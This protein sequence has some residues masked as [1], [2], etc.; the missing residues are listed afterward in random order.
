LRAAAYYR[1]LATTLPPAELGDAALRRVRRAAIRSVHRL[2][3]WRSRVDIQA[4]LGV[5]SVDE[6][7][8]RMRGDRAAR[9][10][11][12]P[13]E[14][15]AAR[16]LFATHFPDHARECCQ[17]ADRILQGEMYLFGVSREHA[18]GELAPGMAA[19]DWTRDPL[20]G[21][22]APARPARLIDRD[23]TGSDSR[24]VW[25][26]G[27]LTAIH[28]LAQAHV[29]IG[30]PGT[31]HARG[32]REPGLYARAVALHLRDFVATQPIGM[33]I[34]WTC[35][36]EAALRLVNITSALTLVR[37]APDLDAF[38]WVEIGEAIVRH[39]RFIHQELEDAQAVPGNHLLTDLA[40]LAI[41]GC[42]FP[43]L[44]DAMDWRTWALPAFERELMRQTTADGLAF[45]A[46]L[47]YHRYAT[48][49]ALLVQAF[50]H[51]QGLSL[52]P[53]VLMRLWRMCDVLESAAL[54][55]G[56]LPAVGDNDGSRAINIQPRGS[57]E[58]A[59]ISAV[60]AALGG[61]GE[62]PSLEPEALWV[63]GLTGFRR[64]L[65]ETRRTVRSER[66]RR[67]AASGLTVLH[68]RDGRA[69]TLWAGDNGQHG[70]G[71]H[72]H[73]D[74]LSCEVVLH[75]RRLTIDPGCPVYQRDPDERDRY[76]STAVHPTLQIDHLEQAPIPA[77]RLFLL[78]DLARAGVLRSDEHT[79]AA[80]HRGYLRLRPGVLHRREVALPPD[81]DGV[82][83]TD[84]VLG[85]GTH[86]VDLR[87]PMPSREV[88]LRRATREEAELLQRMEAAPCGEGRF[89][90]SRVFALGW[91][92]EAGTR[93]VLAIGCE[94]SWEA[95]V[96]ESTW[97]PGYGERV[98]GRTAHICVRAQCPLTI[99]SAFLWVRRAQAA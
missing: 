76:R 13:G 28:W 97:S 94:Q 22:H 27:R 49:L 7:A 9:G 48:E 88:S 74:K 87:W 72:A 69:A 33:G 37:D 41:A 90:T 75:G 14:R 18:R 58:A 82:C 98:C 92:G 67:F 2:V 59:H 51:R 62:R 96:E 93:A 64:N 61:P 63:G 45:E 95:T 73:N 86:V 32:A 84:W 29:L 15:A 6:V 66:A 54:P 80:E 8:G 68:A 36:M 71:G 40:G 52:G 30:L 12:E 38:F 31:E 35:P 89:D 39:G 19:F 23:A 60:R 10:P 44:P 53:A 4:A 47:A 34:H 21:D 57:L 99:T 26:A 17:R 3:P 5:S 25:E 78:P 70:L 55:D 83:V 46:S 81:I 77:G 42:L 11:I 65:V 85:D 16:Q 79:A 56:R 20:A 91:P 50:A 43:E 1:C 24:A